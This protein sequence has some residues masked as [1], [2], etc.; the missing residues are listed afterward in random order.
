MCFGK[1]KSWWRQLGSVHRKAAGAV[2]RNLW[3][4]LPSSLVTAVPPVWCPLLPWQLP[5]LFWHLQGGSSVVFVAS[6]VLP[7]PERGLQGAKC[8]H[9][10]QA[11]V[12]H[13][14]GWQQR[15]DHRQPLSVKRKR[16][17]NDQSAATTHLADDKVRL[18]SGGSQWRWQQ[19]FDHCQEK[20]AKLIG[21]C[22]SPSHILTCAYGHQKVGDQLVTGREE[23]EPRWQWLKCV[24]V[25][26][27][28]TFP[29]RS[30]S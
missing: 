2:T 9:P 21:W 20:W 6:L 11:C 22:P 12:A 24:C 8:C 19:R 27:L 15:F 25:P 7:L 18:R 1:V 30:E 26:F 14:V 29:I 23:T 3:N 17:C 16:T 5:R 13:G 10:P 28:A 4:T